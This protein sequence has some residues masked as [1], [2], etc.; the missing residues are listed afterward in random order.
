MGFA[1][2]RPDWTDDSCDPLFL[3]LA[4]GEGVGVQ[5]FFIIEMR[6]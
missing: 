6:R 4:K 3:P 2:N 1:F 5:E